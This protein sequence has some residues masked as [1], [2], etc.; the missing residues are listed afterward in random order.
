M[1]DEPKSRFTASRGANIEIT[2][3]YNSPFGA[4]APNH[5][6]IVTEA[7]NTRFEAI[8]PFSGRGPKAYQGTKCLHSLS[9]TEFVS[10]SGSE[11]EDASFMNPEPPHEY[12]DGTVKTEIHGSILV[13]FGE[14]E[15]GDI[16]NFDD[17]V[18]KTMKRQIQTGGF[19]KPPKSVGLGET[20]GELGLSAGRLTESLLKLSPP[21]PR[22]PGRWDLWTPD[23]LAEFRSWKDIFHPLEILFGLHPVAE[24]VTE[25]A[26]NA[27]DK[28]EGYAQKA[29]KWVR[30]LKRESSPFRASIKESEFSKDYYP[31]PSDYYGINLAYKKCVFNSWLTGTMSCSDYT[32]FSIPYDIITYY[33]E[34]WAITM[35]DLTSY[36]YLFDRFTGGAVKKMLKAAIKASNSTSDSAFKKN[37]TVIQIYNVQV[38]VKTDTSCR[39][40]ASCLGSNGASGNSRIYNYTRSWPDEIGSIAEDTSPAKDVLDLFNNPITP[41]NG[42]SP[43]QYM[44]V[45]FLFIP[46]LILKSS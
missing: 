45:L 34:S 39:F 17:L 26:L 8:T 21:I 24:Q 38:H 32:E 4:T 33:N 18:R 15:F 41:L 31:E 42:W 30:R 16:F 20:L 7:A 1:T 43:S 40:V 3:Q 27:G 25:L 19:G 29:G 5:T 46:P 23:E 14:F 22:P 37:E 35:W 6:T 11:T 2:V 44:D 12:K 10:I 36:S 13:P 28:A 9:T